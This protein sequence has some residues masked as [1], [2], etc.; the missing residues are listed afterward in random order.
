MRCYILEQ[1]DVGIIGLGPVGAIAAL[2][3]A[4]QRLRVVVIE[5][6]AQVY[7]LPRAIA[8]DNEIL[9]LF[10]LL[11]IQT[12]GEGEFTPS[13]TYQF[14]DEKSELLFG[15]NRSPRDEIDY[16]SQTALFRQPEFEQKVRDLIENEP[17]ITVYLQEELQHFTQN[18]QA[19]QF[20]TTTKQLQATYLLGC[21]GAR[22]QLRKLA[23]IELIELMNYSEPWLIVDTLI[24]DTA[25]T[26][27]VMQQICNPN[28]AISYIPRSGTNNR[29]WEIQIKE[30][31]DHNMIQSDEFIQSILEPW[32]K[33]HEF[34]IE[35]TAIYTF[36]ALEAKKWRDNRIF[37]LGDAAHMMPPFLGQG[38]SSGV[39]DAV[40][41]SWKLAGV[42]HH[43]LHP[44][45]LKTYELER[46]EHVRMITFVAIL[47]GKILM[48]NEKSTVFLRN[49]VM[50][51]LHLLPGTK[52]K[53]DHLYFDIPKMHDFIRSANNGNPSKVGRFKNTEIQ[54]GAQIVLLDSLIKLQFGIITFGKAIPK[55]NHKWFIL[56]AKHIHI[57]PKKHRK[58]IHA[59]QSHITIVEDFSGIYA[60]YFK[61]L[62]TNGMIIRPDK[63][64]L[65]TLNQ[66]RKLLKTL[67]NQVEY[68][69]VSFLKSPTN[70]S[71]LKHIWE[72][73]KNLLKKP[74]LSLT[75]I[76]TISIASLAMLR[77]RG[78]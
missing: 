28:R 41:L 3:L 8:V 62:N 61:Q 4:R 23:E 31:D 2:A 66:S 74:L 40:N 46:K 25:K 6:E 1:F 49:A 29:R 70:L 14:C 77:K 50:K 42:I 64:I 69:A 36:R 34:K 78:K 51:L 76:S 72:E 43:Q 71:L 17:L 11:D 37:L 32:V 75:A 21:D 68:P 58:I 24:L 54:D 13:Y 73:N 16:W 18:E 44:S 22:S 5:K 48:M 65:G 12:N 35:R 63:Y 27:E 39:R 53:V 7:P 15:I 30:N 59:S 20:S 45:I 33:P 9:R 10:S 47:L 19:V 67:T 55:I 56:G 38:L 26:P 52:E 57:V 60:D